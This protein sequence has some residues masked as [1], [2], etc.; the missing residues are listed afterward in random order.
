MRWPSGGPDRRPQR[1]RIPLGGFARCSPCRSWRVSDFTSIVQAVEDGLHLRDLRPL[2]FKNAAADVLD[3]LIRDCASSH[4][5]IAP[6]REGRSWRELRC[7]AASTVRRIHHREYAPYIQASDTPSMIASPPVNGTAPAVPLAWS[8][9]SFGRWLLRR[10]CVADRYEGVVAPQVCRRCWSKAHRRL[11]RKVPSVSETN[12]KNGEGTNTSG[13]PI[14]V[15]IFASRRRCHRDEPCRGR[16]V[17][18]G[19]VPLT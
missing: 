4:M 1:G 11:T 6:E 10:A 13:P 17:H 14:I 9:V 3:L 7:S 8:C 5:S 2:A 19:V 16:D 12:N 18:S 15:P